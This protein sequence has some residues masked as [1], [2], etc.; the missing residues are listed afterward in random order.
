MLAEPGPNGGRAVWGRLLGTVHLAACWKVLPNLPSGPQLFA[1]KSAVQGTVRAAVRA[2]V[3]AVASRGRARP[4]TPGPAGTYTGAPS[5]RSKA[6]MIGGAKRVLGGRAGG[7]G[8]GELRAV[9]GRFLD[10][11]LSTACLHVRPN[12]PSGP[13]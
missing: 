5:F 12:L 10:T 7:Q 9:W 3:S 4:T 2:F 11:L 1:V 6:G 8:R 13:Q